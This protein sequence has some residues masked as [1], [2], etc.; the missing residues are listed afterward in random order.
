MGF[1]MARRSM[2]KRVWMI[3]GRPWR[4]S[5][6][7]RRRPR[8]GTMSSRR[9]R[10]P[11]HAEIRCKADR[12]RAGDLFLGLPLFPIALLEHFLRLVARQVGLPP[13][14]AGVTVAEPGQDDLEGFRALL[15]RHEC[16]VHAADGV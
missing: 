1:F 15:F 6:I 8:R 7:S 12:K 2:L 11:D 3:L 16:F 9:R 5:R 13:V 14:L 10:G 4:E